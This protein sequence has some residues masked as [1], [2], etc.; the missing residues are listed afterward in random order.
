VPRLH[1]RPLLIVNDT[2]R[3]HLGDDSLGFRV[4]TRDTLSRVR[5]LQVAQLV[6]NETA[7]VQLVV[8]DAGAALRV[9]VD[10]ARAPQRATWA[11]QSFP[12]QVL[13]AICFGEMPAT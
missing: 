4:R 8:Q 7:D 11:A 10:R 3:R 9:A 2:Q 6:P 13:F 5:V 1:R 12:I